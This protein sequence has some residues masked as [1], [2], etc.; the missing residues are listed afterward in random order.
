[1][2]SLAKTI[3]AAIF[4]NFDRESIVVLSNGCQIITTPDPEA[5]RELAL[6]IEAAILARGG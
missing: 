5:V 6:E 1:M 2:T 4:E 3:E